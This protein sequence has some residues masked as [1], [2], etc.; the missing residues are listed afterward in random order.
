MN[1]RGFIHL[2]PLIL[3]ILVVGAGFLV[4]KG[5]IKL[6]VSIPFLQNQPKVELKTEYKNPF[7][8]ETQYVNPFQT[9]KNPF[10]TN[11]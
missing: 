6:P 7:K 3:V 8:K 1:Q 2:L 4:Y 9:Y 11:R 5:I 10:V